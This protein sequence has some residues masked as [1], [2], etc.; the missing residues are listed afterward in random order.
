MSFTSKVY[1]RREALQTLGLFALACHP[2][3]NAA[4]APKQRGIALQLYTLREPA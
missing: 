1:S 3:L 2:L 4:A